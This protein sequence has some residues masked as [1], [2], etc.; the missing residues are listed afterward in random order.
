[1]LLN[2][3]VEIFL[4]LRIHC[5]EYQVFSYV[6]QFATYLFSA[7]NLISFLST[8]C[9]AIWLVSMITSIRTNF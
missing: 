5:T 1:M 8:L 6:L 9:Y 2:V 7:A 4:K 3:Q